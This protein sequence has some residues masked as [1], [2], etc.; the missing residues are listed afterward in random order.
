MVSTLHGSFFN[1]ELVIKLISPFIM[2]VYHYAFVA[3]G[4][5][6]VRFLRMLIIFLGNKGDR[7]K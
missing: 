5:E 3:I 1:D 6:C 7:Q 2:L 4:A